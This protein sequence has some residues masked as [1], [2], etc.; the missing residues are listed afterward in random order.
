MDM[1]I[2]ISDV[3]ARLCSDYA[4][5]FWCRRTGVARG[6]LMDVS[7][8]VFKHYV[9]RGEQTLQRDFAELEKRKL[10]RREGD[11]FFANK[12]LVL[13]YLPPMRQ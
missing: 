11:L 12:A 7:V 3:S 8:R 1:E 13:A 5:H 9:G 10:V 2:H 4:G 6:K